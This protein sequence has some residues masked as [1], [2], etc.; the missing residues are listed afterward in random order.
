MSVAEFVA[1]LLPSLVMPMA[2]VRNKTGAFYLLFDASDY[3]LL[4]RIYEAI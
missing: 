4:N 3:K 1:P 2:T